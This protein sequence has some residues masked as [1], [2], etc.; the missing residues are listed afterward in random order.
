VIITG[1]SMTA[2]VQQNGQSTGLYDGAFFV[3]TGDTLFLTYGSIP[4]INKIAE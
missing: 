4:T 2:Y 1:G 3:R